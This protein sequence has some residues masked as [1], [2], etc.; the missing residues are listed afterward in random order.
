MMLGVQS[1]AFLTGTPMINR[2][3][4]LAGLLDLAWSLRL[5]KKWPEGARV[6]E[7]P[8]FVAADQAW[9]EA[10]RLTDPTVPDAYQS[11]VFCWSSHDIG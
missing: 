3:Q 7:L 8:D 5:A 11:A 2:A 10:T 1:L 9:E 6:P 4:D